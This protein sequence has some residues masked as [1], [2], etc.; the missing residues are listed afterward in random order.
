MVLTVEKRAKWIPPFD[1][2]K[3]LPKEEQIEIEYDKP[4]AYKKTE[5]TRTCSSF[6]EK[7]KVAA[8][9]DRDTR[10]II[11]ESNVGIK[12]LSVVEDGETKEIKTGEDLLNA[13]SVVCSYLVTALVNVILQDD[14]KA[15]LPS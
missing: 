12:N 1:E 3:K 7:G 9:V 8:Y 10:R 14:Y 5:W 13:R 4:L 11:R 2:N 15:E 6:N